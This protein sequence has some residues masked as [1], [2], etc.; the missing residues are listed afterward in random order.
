M[1]ASRKSTRSRLEND[2]ETWRLTT[3]L[4]RKPNFFGT[5]PLLQILRDTR[6]T[7]S[8]TLMCSGRP[9][10][11]M[12]ARFDC[13][14]YVSTGPWWAC[15]MQNLADLVV[16][17]PRVTRSL[18]RP[19][20]RGCVSLT[21]SHKG[22]KATKARRT[23][24]LRPP[25]CPARLKPD[26]RHKVGAATRCPDASFLMIFISLWCWKYNSYAAIL[27]DSF[28]ATDE[29]GTLMVRTSGLTCTIVDMDFLKLTRW[30]VL[31][32]AHPLDD[33]H[34]SMRRLHWLLLYLKNRVKSFFMDWDV[35]KLVF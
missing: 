33:R 2:C 9:W 26:Y 4:S 23:R 32:T 25:R 5:L 20:I 13:D 8:S 6:H 7:T 22:Y 19:L 28:W 35:W 31:G 10:C 30:W 1:G 11:G 16:W 12:L 21:P 15:L 34:L 24:D 18:E 29:C 17:G 14:R 3:E 27:G